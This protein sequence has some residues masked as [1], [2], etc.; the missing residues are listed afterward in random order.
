[1]VVAVNLGRAFVLAV[2]VATIVSGT[3]SIVLVLVAL[4][5][6]GTAE[7]FADAASSTLLPGLVAREDLG[8]A[9]AR[10]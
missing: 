4:F 2:L 8:V 1:M 5:M 7:T 6:L 9:N 3:V 10:M